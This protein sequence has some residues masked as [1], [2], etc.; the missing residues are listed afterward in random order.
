VRRDWD[1]PEQVVKFGTRE[2]DRGADIAL[3]QHRREILYAREVV[4]V[5]CDDLLRE[6]TVSAPGWPPNPEAM[7]NPAE[8]TRLGSITKRCSKTIIWREI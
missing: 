1:K 2:G 8:E 4:N 3:K 6:W 5:N 7:I